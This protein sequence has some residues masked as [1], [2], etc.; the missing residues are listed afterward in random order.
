MALWKDLQN[1]EFK[2]LLTNR[3]NQDCLENL[4]LIL[5]SK[6]R[7]TDN[8]DPQQFRAAFRHAIIDKLFVL[9]T[10][11]NCVLD[12]DKILLDFSNVKKNKRKLKKHHRIQ[13]S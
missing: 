7:F 9:R 2:Y 10:S 11:A 1:S 5:R 12:A 4:F 6:G 8:P 13:W 3:L